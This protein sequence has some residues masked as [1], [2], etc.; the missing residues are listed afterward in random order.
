MDRSTIVCVH[1]PHSEYEEAV[2][3]DE[4]DLL[5]VFFLNK[6]K[7][8]GAKNFY[9]AAEVN[10]E[11]K[12]QEDEDGEERGRGEGGLG[13]PFCWDGGYVNNLCG[14]RLCVIAIAWRPVL[15]RAYWASLTWQ[16]WGR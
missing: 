12:L 9:I 8:R 13:G 4:M 5:S 7:T 6:G 16:G 2:C 1:M 3:E 10:L 11:S 14:C 15:G